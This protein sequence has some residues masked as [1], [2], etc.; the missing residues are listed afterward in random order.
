[1]KRYRF[2]LISVTFVVLLFFL[3]SIILVKASGTFYIR[4]DGSVEGTDN[5]QLTGN[6]YSF[7]DNINGSIVVEKDNIVIDGTNFTLQG[8][9]SEAG[10]ILAH[11]NNVTVKNV[12]IMDFN[13][14]IGLYVADHNSF[15]RNLL[16]NN[17]AGISLM[18]SD[19]NTI[20]GNTIM[21]NGNGIRL[22]HSSN[23]SIYDNSFINNTKQVHDSIWDQPWLP[24]LPSQNMWGNSTTG[25]YWSDY[26]RTGDTPYI[27]DENNQD[28]N[29]LMEP[30]IIPEFP[31]WTMM[32]LVISTIAIV[33]VIYKRR[34]PTQTK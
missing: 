17:K 27:I 4:A 12:Q 10:I 28:N 29:P 7:T 21:N 30:T 34:L 8:D 15:S 5:I 6:V 25:N 24:Q 11:Q 19:N 23:N 1:M 9:G 16:V 3:L 20:T 22:Y 31:S 33:L 18:D 14:G 2:N 26:D 13:T 32:L